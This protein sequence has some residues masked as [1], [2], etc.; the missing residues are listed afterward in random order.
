MK[1]PLVALLFVSA[2]LAG[3]AGSS[4]VTDV[5]TKEPL[6]ANKGGIQGILV[7]DRYRPVAQAKILLFPVGA[8]TN[9]NNNGEFQFGNLDPGTYTAQV[10]AAGHEA[11]PTDVDVVVG[12]YNHMEIEARRVSSD[13]SLILTA[14]YSAFVP[15]AADFVANGIV[16]NCL[17][18]LSGDT[19]RP[20][21]RT[22]SRGLGANITF[23]VSEAKISQRGDWNIQVREDDGS[24]SG[25]ER[26]AVATIKDGTYVKITN[27]YNV[28]NTEHNGQDNNVPWTNDKVFATIMFYQGAMRD[29]IRETSGGRLC[30]G[31]GA[32]VAVKGTFMQSMFVGP[33]QVDV[34]AYHVMSEDE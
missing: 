4:E 31:A 25:G 8:T 1:A 33:P 23:L 26:Y 21:F 3:C 32:A 30:C 16:A 9:S 29:E 22:D 15:C 7:D 11:A 6:Q 27:E 17:L 18:D 5:L 34:K 19:Y 10:E 24:S 13:G 28:T 12:I 20:S 14:Q 2:A